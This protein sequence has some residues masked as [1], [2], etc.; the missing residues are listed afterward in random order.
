G[1][2]LYC[3]ALGLEMGLYETP[4]QHFGRLDM[5]MWRA[6]RLVVDTGLHTQDWTREQAV[7]YMSED[8]ALPRVTIESEVDRYIGMPAQALAYQVGNLKF[9]ELRRRVQRRLGS[10]FDVRTFH[11]TVIAAGAVTLP[12]LERL[13]EDYIIFEVP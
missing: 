2:A 12:V 10:R 8:Q 5:E 13:V 6:L 11:D 4:H 7:A 9:C 1:W 3:E